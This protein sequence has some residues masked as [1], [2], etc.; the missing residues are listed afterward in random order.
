MNYQDNLNL[1]NTDLSY[2][3]FGTLFEFSIEPFGILR[4]HGYLSFLNLPF[5]C[6]TWSYVV[7]L[8]YELTIAMPWHGLTWDLCLIV[9]YQCHVLTWSYMIS[10]PCKTYQCHAL[11][12]SYLVSLNP[13]VM[14]FVSYTFLRFN[15]DF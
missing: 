11:A 13:N 14:T 8:P 5:P 4:I 3:S 9:V 6:L 2:L 10:L 15:R 12:W 7:S 1:S